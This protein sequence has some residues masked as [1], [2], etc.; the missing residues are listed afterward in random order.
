MIK[1]SGIK[2]N[3]FHPLAKTPS[4]G[5]WCHDEDFE[6]QNTGIESVRRV[7]RI[8]TCVHLCVY[9]CFVIWSELQDKILIIIFF[10]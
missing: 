10:S 3:I 7:Q 1:L 9:G 8:F 2:Y 4:R 6:H 5:E